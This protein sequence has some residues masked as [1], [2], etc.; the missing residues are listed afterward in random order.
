MHLGLCRDKGSLTEGT[1]IR[2]TLQVTV[3]LRGG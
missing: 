1:L 2:G 3:V